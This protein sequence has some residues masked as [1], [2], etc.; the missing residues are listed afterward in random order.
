MRFLCCLK[1]EKTFS[2]KN[3]EKEGMISEIYYKAPSLVYKKAS[4]KD[5]YDNAEAI[6]LAY[7][8]ECKVGRRLS[9]SKGGFE[10]SSVIS[11]TNV[12]SY[13]SYNKERCP[14]ILLAVFV[15]RAK[16]YLAGNILEV[17]D[18]PLNGV[19]RPQRVKVHVRLLPSKR[20]VIK[21]GWSENLK[22]EM[23]MKAFFMEEF[24]K[25]ISG[26]ADE[27][28]KFLRFRVYGPQK[29]VGEC[30]L[31][32]DEVEAEKGTEMFWMHLKQKNKGTN[33]GE[34]EDSKH[35]LKDQEAIN[36]M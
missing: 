10:K 31:D 12:S 7:S 19:D 36:L 14:Q 5:E 6:A 23:S 33:F 1:P 28:E 11:S 25:S 16:K 26:F 35:L 13:Y 8:A 2:E 21:T 22:D 9:V 30:Y 4:G 18:I 20:V 27:S 15:S 34:N 32:I 29:C 3:T 24:R 17:D